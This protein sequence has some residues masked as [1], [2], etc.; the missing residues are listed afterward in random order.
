MSSIRRT[1]A[2]EICACRRFSMGR[3]GQAAAQRIPF[4]P[5]AGRRCRQAD[6][7]WAERHNLPY[8]CVSR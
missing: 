3:R 7:G 1:G 4:A 2:Q 5:T 6:E 8:R